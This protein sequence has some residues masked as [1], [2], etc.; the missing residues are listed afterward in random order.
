M[1][2]YFC[3]WLKSSTG[4]TYKQKNFFNSCKKNA[5]VLLAFLET[6]S[7]IS[8]YSIKIASLDSDISIDKYLE[9][10][11]QESTFRWQ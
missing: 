1:G 6:Y 5:L 7:S 9:S 4:L 11:D 8:Y 10:E 3:K 2:F